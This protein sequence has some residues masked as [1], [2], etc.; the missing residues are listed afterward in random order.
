MI[1]QTLSAERL[2]Y[3]RKVM[4]EGRGW[5]DEELKKMMRYYSN[6]RYVGSVPYEEFVNTVPKHEKAEPPYHQLALEGV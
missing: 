6:L 4:K 1:Q 2:E 5:T 3:L